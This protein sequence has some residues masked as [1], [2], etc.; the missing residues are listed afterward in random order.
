[1]AFVE[2]L[3][4]WRQIAFSLQADI[5]TSIY[6]PGTR[7]PTEADL[8]ARFGVNRHT[9]RRAIQSLSE[10]GKLKVEQGRGTFVLEEPLDYRVGERT[11][12]SQN[13]L[14][15]QRLPSRK[16]VRLE[17]IKADQLVARSL[18]LRAGMEVVLYQCVSFADDKP[19]SLGSSFL[20]AH[21]FADI[22]PHIEEHKSLTT[23][24][25]KV[26]VADYTRQSTRII[27]D[28]P[29]PEESRHLKIPRNRPILRTESVN[30]DTAN[31]PIEFGIGRFVADR[32]Q[33]LVD[34]GN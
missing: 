25:K 4:I 15:N 10:E 11:R 24:L 26:G 21:R 30:V 8:V 28:M 12:F 3:P 14:Q 1:M 5:E 9:V 7:L 31:L 34:S 29:S 16:L 33:L 2:G 19:V 6:P 27:G 32:V 18:M 13:V 23:A 22:I 20:P 17:I